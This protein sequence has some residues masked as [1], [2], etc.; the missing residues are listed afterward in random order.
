[1]AKF[2]SNKDESVRLFKNPVLEFFSHIH[3]VTPVIIYSPVIL[4]FGWQGL[5]K[6]G[7]GLLAVFFVV[8]VL[9]WTF[10]EY[11]LHRF[12]FH[13][14]PKTSWGKYLHFLSH[15]IHHD[16]PRDSTRLVMPLLISVPIAIVTYIFFMVVFGM[17]HYAVFSGIVFGYVCYDSIHYAAHHFKMKGR[18]GNFLKVYHLKHHYSDDHSGYGVSNPLWDYIFGTAPKQTKLPEAVAVV[19]NSQKIY[20]EEKL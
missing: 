20:K 12:V 19:A 3:P 5:N 15:G 9:C 10:I 1:M 6:T 14:E 2:V 4:Y 7:F 16:Y 8:G 11:F 17:Y 18:I 13:Y